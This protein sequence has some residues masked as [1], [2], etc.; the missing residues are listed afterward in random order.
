MKPAS[1]RLALLCEQ[2]KQRRKAVPR[3]EL[4][5]LDVVKREPVDQMRL[6]DWETTRRRGPRRNGALCARLRRP[7]RGRSRCTPRRRPEDRS[8]EELLLDVTA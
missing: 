7:G 8:G 5:R 6:A 4:G 1:Q 3:S 2:G